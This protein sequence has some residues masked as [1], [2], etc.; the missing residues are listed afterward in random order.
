MFNQI[1]LKIIIRKCNKTWY[2]IY[3]FFTVENK[4]KLG[5]KGHAAFY[6]FSNLRQLTWNIMYFAWVVQKIHTA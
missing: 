3:V 5:F 1:K 2:Y 4:K 6:S